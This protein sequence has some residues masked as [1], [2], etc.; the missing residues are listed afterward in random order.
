MKKHAEISPSQL[1][2]LE[3]CPAMFKFNKDSGSAA[4]DRGTA[5]HEIME[6]LSLE[7]IESSAFSYADKILLLDALEKVLEIAPAENW[8]VEKQIDLLNS[9]FEILT[10]GTPD[11]WACIDDVI[12]VIDYKFGNI[13]VSANNLQLQVYAMALM[14]Q[15]GI[16]KSILKI[17]QPAINNYDE[18]YFE[19]DIELIDRVEKIVSDCKGD[20]LI[21]SCGE[22][23]KY[24]S[25]NDRCPAFNYTVQKMTISDIC[26]NDDNLADE[27]EKASAIKKVINDRFEIVAST[28]KEHL[29]ECENE[30]YKLQNVKGKNEI[31]D[32]DLFFDFCLKELDRQTVMEDVSF[33][34]GKIENKFIEK[35]KPSG[36]KVKEIKEYFND[37][38]MPFCERG[39]GYDKIV[40]I[41]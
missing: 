33:S 30:K 3:Q 18:H 15:Q 20:K 34:I 1:E 4:A 12:Y 27:Y 38:I 31:K 28:V 36:W 9:E 24:C 19:F 13:P 39:A 7:S 41:K 6:K 22:S 21:F 16:N 11:A 37:G 14:Q 5:M 10:F 8:T 23:C 40:K 29:R 32:K 26:I 35:M 25:Y 2:K 17:I